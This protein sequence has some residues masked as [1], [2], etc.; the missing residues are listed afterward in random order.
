MYLGTL[1]NTQH[2]RCQECGSDF[3]ESPKPRACVP[4][5]G[6]GMSG[7]L[8]RGWQRQNRHTNPNPNSF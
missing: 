7:R 2:F 8:F 5:R 3:C 1:G 4:T 6:S